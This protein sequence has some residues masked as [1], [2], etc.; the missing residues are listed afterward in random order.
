M[1]VSREPYSLGPKGEGALRETVYRAGMV[2]ANTSA[3]FCLHLS[4]SLSV[5][6]KSRDSPKVS[7]YRS[8]GWAL[9]SLPIR[10]GLM[11]YL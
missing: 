11:G 10:P 6:W 3:H 7:V 4:R 8:W 9:L 1:E 2:G 5:A